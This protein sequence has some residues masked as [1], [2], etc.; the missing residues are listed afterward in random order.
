MWI[1][2][3]CHSTPVAGRWLTQAVIALAIHDLKATIS[4]L[5]KWFHPIDETS[6]VLKHAEILKL[7]DVLE[8]I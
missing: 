5:I 6:K 1:A 4:F 2:L 7:V 3:V 8:W